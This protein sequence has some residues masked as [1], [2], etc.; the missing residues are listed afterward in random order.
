[1]GKFEALFNEDENDI[2]IG[3]AKSKFLDVL[4]NANSE[5]VAEELDK[6]IE[7]FAAMELLLTQNDEFEKV[8]QEYIFKNS[9]EVHQMKK[10]LY[11]EFTGEIISRLDS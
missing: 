3:S 1:M 6:I 10:S 11:M 8:L 4:K 5:V 2:L 7:K 9:S